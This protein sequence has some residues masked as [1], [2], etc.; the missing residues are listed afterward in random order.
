M[1]QALRDIDRGLVDTDRRGSYGMGEDVG[2]QGKR[3]NKRSHHKGNP[4]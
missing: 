2:L 3:R 1:R 4:K